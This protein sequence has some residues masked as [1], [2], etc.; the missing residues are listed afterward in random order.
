MLRININIAIVDM[1]KRRTVNQEIKAS[2]C[3]SHNETTELV[4]ANSGSEI[5]ATYVSFI[6]DNLKSCC[7]ILPE[8]QKC[9]CS[10]FK[11]LS[12]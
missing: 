4:S 8:L 7:S 12:I 6:I 2:Q 11:I 9:I 10:F 1:V 3:Y 5:S